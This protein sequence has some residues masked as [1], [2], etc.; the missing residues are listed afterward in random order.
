MKEQDAPGYSPRSEV[1]GGAVI[2]TSRAD[3]FVWQCFHVL[4]TLH[5][6][7]TELDSTVFAC[8]PLRDLTLP[9]SVDK[10]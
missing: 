8:P 6:A 1:V 2:Y 10:L 9:L 4:V 5:T 3:F 7:E